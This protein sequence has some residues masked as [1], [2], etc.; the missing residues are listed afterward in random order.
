V[1]G[2]E[3]NPLTPALSPQA[4]RGSN[5]R[6]V[7]TGSIAHSPR[8]GRRGNGVKI[9]VVAQFAVAAVSDRRKLLKNKVR[10]SE[11]AATAAKM[12]H[13]QN[14]GQELLSPLARLREWEMLILMP[15]LGV[16]VGAADRKF[17]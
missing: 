16:G 5:V 9:R 3:R 2:D 15:I 6:C 13:Y 11:T 14:K 10:R 1:E 8:T 4:G 12:Y 17:R 7:L